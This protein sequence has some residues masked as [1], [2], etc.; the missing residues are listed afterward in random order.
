MTSLK[1]KTT[2][3][4]LNTNLTPHVKQKQHPEQYST[5]TGLTFPKYQ[6]SIIIIIIISSS[7]SSSIQPLGLFW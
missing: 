6:R 7:S 5:T 1:K 2:K 3:M 4:E